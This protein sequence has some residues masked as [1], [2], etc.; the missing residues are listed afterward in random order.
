MNPTKIKIF[1][2]AGKVVA[3]D[4]R[5]SDGASERSVVRRAEELATEARDLLALV[6]AMGSKLGDEDKVEEARR[7]AEREEQQKKWREIQAAEELKRQKQKE[8]A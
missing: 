7:H 2:S 6:A 5:V 1:L 4:F 8:T 3:V